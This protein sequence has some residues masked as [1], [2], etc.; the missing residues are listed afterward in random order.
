MQEKNRRINKI[1]KK[2]IVYF[3]RFTNYYNEGKIKESDEGGT[4]SMIVD[5]RN[6][7]KVLVTKPEEKR[8]VGRP[9]HGSKGN[10]KTY[11]K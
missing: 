3:A 2:T 6:A 10:I 9:V 4:R 7:C 11:L 5:M 1:Y 8:K